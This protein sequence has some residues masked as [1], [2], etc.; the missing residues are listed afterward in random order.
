MSTFKQHISICSLFAQKVGH[1][2]GG[3]VDGWM[4]VGAGLQRSKRGRVKH[5]DSN[6]SNFKSQNR[7]CVILLVQVHLRLQKSNCT[8]GFGQKLKLR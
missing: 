7:T 2:M 1:W 5:L 6:S 4:D 8:L 3:W